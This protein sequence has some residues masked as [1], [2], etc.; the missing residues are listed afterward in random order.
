M[1]LGPN[2][3][4]LDLLHLGTVVPYMF[5]PLYKFAYSVQE[6]LDGTPRDPTPPSS[7]DLAAAAP[8][9]GF[10][11]VK[12]FPVYECAA[13]SSIAARPPHPELSA[14]PG[15][16]EPVVAGTSSAGPERGYGVWLSFHR[17]GHLISR[18]SSGII[19][20]AT[21][22]P[23]SRRRGA[24]CHQ[25]CPPLCRG[26]MDSP[27]PPPPHYRIHLTHGPQR[28]WCLLR[29]L[30]RPHCPGNHCARWIHAGLW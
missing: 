15:P 18:L 12:C 22:F 14:S 20:L 2:F 29:L 16:W 8:S 23:R 27:P 28:G 7:P 26:V 21:C 30:R 1:H 3:C 6:T 25:I 13:P 19:A 24:A 10:S 9:L 17:T 5:L 4:Y 11:A